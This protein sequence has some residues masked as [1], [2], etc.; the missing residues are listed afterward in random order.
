[1]T[2]ISP[3][4]MPPFEP[5]RAIDRAIDRAAA[6]S[7][8][9]FRAALRKADKAVARLTADDGPGPLASPPAMAAS[10][11]RPRAQDSMHGGH[12]GHSGSITASSS[13]EPSGARADEATADAAHQPGAASSPRSL[14]GSTASHADGPAARTGRSP[15]SPG[16]NDPLDA[17][18]DPNDDATLAGS[19]IATA[20]TVAPPSTGG[21]Q[22][23]DS[24]VTAWVA[25]AVARAI[26]SLG[27]AARAAAPASAGENAAAAPAAVAATGIDVALP[28]LSPLEQ[29]VH[30]LIGRASARDPDDEHA[31]KPG[32]AAAPDF[33]SVALHVLAADAPPPPVHDVRAAAAAPVHGAPVAQLPEPFAN[34]SHVH[35]VLDDGPERTVVTVAVRG[36]EVRV[37]LRASDEAT[38][39]SLARNAASLDHAMRARG[40]A[41]GELTTEREPGDQR[42]SRDPEPRERRAPDE[43]PFELEDKP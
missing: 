24:P 43:E 10:A 22:I 20:P 5:E 29:A 12:S 28:A 2:R 4:P 37:A 26:G 14:G 42:P 39:A 15:G 21:A 27:G 13:H 30:D 33:A 40:L 3:S 35:L 6:S 19:G 36:S 31:A 9:P 18:D 38:A 1:M 25:A 8:T 11:P 34:P 32:T 41:L 7:G 17:S 23:D 16:T